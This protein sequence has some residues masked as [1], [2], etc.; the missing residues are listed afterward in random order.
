MSMDRQ[1]R[2]YRPRPSTPSPRNAS[3]GCSRCYLDENSNKRAAFF[4]GVHCTQKVPVHL[5]SPFC[6]LTIK[7]P[8]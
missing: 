1:T 5:F 6:A 4:S 3:Y 2:R 7:R 8:I